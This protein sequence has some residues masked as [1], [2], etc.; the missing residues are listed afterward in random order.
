VRQRLAEVTQGLSVSAP[1]EISVAERG[2]ARIEG[3]ASGP[4]NAALNA[5][6][7]DMHR[8]L[9]R[10]APMMVP[11]SH[12]EEGASTSTSTL[13]FGSDAPFFPSPLPHPLP[14]RPAPSRHERRGREQEGKPGGFII[15]R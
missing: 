5:A 1:V 8:A 12:G 3:R 10:S 15:E 9:Q 6:L 11:D 13:F 14:T 2:T 4:L 7:A